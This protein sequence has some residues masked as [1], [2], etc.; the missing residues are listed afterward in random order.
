MSTSLDYLRL[1]ESEVKSWNRD[2]LE[3]SARSQDH[4]FPDRLITLLPSPE[5]DFAGGPRDIQSSALHSKLSALCELFLSATPEQRT[6]IRSM[7]NEKM[8]GKLQAFGFRTAVMGARQNNDHL[9]RLGLAAHA[10][11][12]VVT[13]DV[14]DALVLLTILFNA[15]RRIRADP[16]ILFHEV[17]MISGPA[18]RSVMLDFINRPPHLQ[19]LS[20]MGF[21]E[22][23]T[24]DGVWYQQSE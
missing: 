19:T 21:M 10:V 14:R 4:D 8:G 15:A 12:D 11:E 1:R 17:A 5:E 22:V 9:I 13:G 16:G 6:F 3:E 7:I 23:E 2:A 24:C 20:C 18:M